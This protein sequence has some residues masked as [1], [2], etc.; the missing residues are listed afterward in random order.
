MDRNVCGL[1]R[2]V[3]FTVATLLAIAALGA[4][5]GRGAPGTDGSVARWQILALYASAELLV[6]GLL[7]WCPL[8]YALGVDS[9]EGS[10]LTAIRS[11]A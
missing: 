9:C 2:F 4:R 11:R 6:T 3:R 5:R 7:Q 10:W 8:N 1:D